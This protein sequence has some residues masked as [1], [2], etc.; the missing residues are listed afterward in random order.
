VLLVGVSLLLVVDLR[1]TAATLTQRSRDAF[2]FGTTLR[3]F[4]EHEIAR[5]AVVVLAF[6]VIV[7]RG[8]VVALPLYLQKDMG[9]GNDALIY[10]VAPGV[11]G[12]AAGLLWSSRAVTFARSGGIMRVSLMGMIVSVFALA[13]LDY[14]LAAF[15]QYSQVPPIARLEASMNTTFVVALPVAFLLGLSLSGGLISSRVA[16]TETAPAGQQARVFAVQ[17]TL[18]DVLLVLPLIAAGVGTQFAG[19]RITLAAIGVLA[20]LAIV[21][22]ELPRL[23]RRASVPTLELESAPDTISA[24]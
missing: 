9:L 23:A 13:V 14:G 11:L 2:S 1:G 17:G 10:L 24:A 4:A 20:V 22:L 12:V 15:A 18:T 19:A 6:Q 16:L 21:A 3:L 7:G 5:Y 8:I